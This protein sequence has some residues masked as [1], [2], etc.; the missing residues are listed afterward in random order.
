MPFFKFKLPK[1][2]GTN[3]SIYGDW[4][5]GYIIDGSGVYITRNL[6]YEG[7][8]DLSNNVS[9]DNGINGLVVHKTTNEN[10]KVKV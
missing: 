3:S 7:T 2:G 10:V 4:N 6:A 5:Q 8:F 1:Y 9:F